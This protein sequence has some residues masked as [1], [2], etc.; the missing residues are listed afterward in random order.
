MFERGVEAN[1]SLRLHSQ[2]YFNLA[3]YL[4]CGYTPSKGNRMTAVVDSPLTVFP[5]LGIALTLGAVTALLAWL[6]F[7]AVMGLSRQLTPAADDRR[8]R[9]VPPWKFRCLWPAI[10]CLTPLV[11]HLLGAHRRQ[12][13][14]DHLTRAGW[15]YCLDADQ[16]C[17]ALLSWSLLL[18]LVGVTVAALLSG[19]MWLAASCG[20]SLGILLPVL[21]LNDQ[22]QQRRRDILRALPFH[23]DLITLCVEAGLNLQGAIQQ[24]VQKGAPGPLRAEWQ[25][26]LRDVRA[27]KPRQQ[28]LQAMAERVS[29]PALTQMV[30]VL[31]QAE[32]VGMT[33]AP[34]L[35]AQAEQRRNERYLRAEKLA[36][37]AP[38]KMLLPLVACIFPCTFLIIGFPIG[39]KLLT[40]SW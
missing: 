20:A 25:R 38:V 18:M 28:A 40:V 32:T 31:G 34:L 16:W 4:V 7:H 23:L 29:V 9:D 39:M 22:I 14:S 19:P 5:P 15:Q 12:R 17:A 6:S 37:Q 2:S 21:W 13:I 26:V 30:S 36:L 35:R 8:W 24:A 3:R 33:L 11:P 10:R 1:P 27:G